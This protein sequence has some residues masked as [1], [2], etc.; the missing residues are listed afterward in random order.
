[1][2]AMPHI[3]FS[4]IALLP[5]DRQQD[6]PLL[7][8]MSIMALLAGLII[9]LT[10]MSTRAVDKWQSGLTQGATL[11][12]KL[13]DIEQR[14]A[15]ITQLQ[16]LLE[17]RGDIKSVSVLSEARAQALLKPWLGGVELPD[18]LP[19]PV[20][21]SLELEPDQRLNVETLEPAIFEQGLDVVI[22]DHSLWRIDIERNRKTLNGALR[23]ILVLIL[24]SS[25][26]VS[27]FATQARLHTQHKTISVLS[28]VG[29]KNSFIARLFVGQFFLRGLIAGIIGC[30]LA[31]LFALV[32]QWVQGDNTVFGKYYIIGSDLI[33][34]VFLTLVFGLI[35]ALTAG[36]TGLSVLNKQNLIY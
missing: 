2:S 8:V 24:L 17:S 26:A 25:M 18:D 13:S 7:F 32:F 12:L 20:L 34:L 16:D 3:S 22:D 31:L 15:E 21:F 9:L 1:M 14:Q 36:F 28:Q 29:A 27:I 4:P 10:M 6:G 30:S 23:T 35:C 33:K 5:G 19:L 11:T